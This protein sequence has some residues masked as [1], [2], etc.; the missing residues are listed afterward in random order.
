MKK[1][2]FRLF[3]QKPRTIG[4]KGLADTFR[5]SPVFR[6]LK[7]P[8]RAGFCESPEVRLG[9]GP[10]QYR[11]VVTTM[12]ELVLPTTILTVANGDT[13][14]WRDVEETF[15]TYMA[16]MLKV[17]FRRNLAAAEVEE[18]SKCVLFS[19]TALGAFGPERNNGPDAGMWLTRRDIPAL[20]AA[21]VVTNTILKAAKSIIESDDWRRL[22]IDLMRQEL[23]SNPG[24]PNWDS[25]LEGHR[26]HQAIWRRS[27]TMTEADELAAIIYSRLHDGEDLPTCQTMYGRNAENRKVQLSGEWRPDGLYYT[28]EAFKMARWRAVFGAPKYRNEPDRLPARLCLRAMKKAFPGMAAKSE[29]V[30]EYQKRIL[31]KDESQWVMG[32]YS[33]FDRNVGMEPMVQLA[34]VLVGISNLIGLPPWQTRMLKDS[35]I[36]SLDTNILVPSHSA[37][38]VAALRKPNGLSSGRIETSVM[39]NFYV[40]CVAVE[41]WSRLHG[42]SMQT[43]ADLLSEAKIPLMWYGDDVNANN[44]DPEWPEAF[45][46]TSWK[47]GQTIDF[48]EGDVFL[49]RSHGHMISARAFWRTIQYERARPLSVQA[50]GLLARDE[51]MKGH[52]TYDL[53]VRFVLKAMRIAGAGWSSMR[54]VEREANYYIERAAAGQNT[55][56]LKWFRRERH[57]PGGESVLRRFGSLYP[58]LLAKVLPEQNNMMTRDDALVEI[59]TYLLQK[60]GR[61]LENR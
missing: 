46:A 1:G 38:G 52:P 21:E 50:V 17:P 25:S 14:V 26:L 44:V 57:S 15:D 2:G 37:K 41:A 49:R 40:C 28:T 18:A 31:G 10:I 8:E 34:P 48:P 5:G 32:D 59:D 12:G 33:R 45:I 47:Y 4:G 9:R 3:R 51:Q 23:S 56:L 27:R 22:E 16:E 30:Y 6:A 39:S 54:D 20:E 24:Y 29:E 53:W 60:T 7:R 42:V 61:K 55:D 35:W 43:A 36:S 58:G 13:D 19:S 11:R